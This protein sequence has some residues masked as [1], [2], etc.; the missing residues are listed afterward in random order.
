MLLSDLV[1]VSLQPTVTQ[2]I[3]SEKTS[4]TTPLTTEE[5][6]TVSSPTPT[7][8]RDT[9]VTNSSSVTITTEEHVTHDTHISV[10]S[11]PATH[12]DTY[13]LPKSTTLSHVST[14]SSSTQETARDERR[15][16]STPH[17]S[18]E[19]PD[20]VSSVSPEELANLGNIL[21]NP[22]TDWKVKNVDKGNF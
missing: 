19:H 20:D 8:G 2:M 21:Q 9:G 17:R 11:S 3:N 6:T 14:E 4:H 13:H 1:T 16:K 15:K 5:S 22:T 10:T 12:N 7:V 18:T